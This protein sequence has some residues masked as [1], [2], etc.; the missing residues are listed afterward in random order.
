MSGVAGNANNGGCFMDVTLEIKN[1]QAI[2]RA[3]I[4]IKDFEEFRNIVIAPEYRVVNL[5]LLEEKLKNRIYAILANDELRK[6]YIVSCYVG[7]SYPSLTLEKPSLQMYERII[8]EDFGVEPIGHPFLKPVRK[9]DNYE[10]L[11]SSDNQTH[12]V[13]VGP[14]HAGIIE[15]GHFRFI[16]NGERVNHLEIQLG[17]QHRGVEKLLKNKPSVQLAESICGDSTIAYSLAFCRAMEALAG[18]NIGS[19]ERLIRL[20][21]LEMERMAIHI[22][23]IGAIAGD[24][25]YY[26]A[27]D[28]LA[29]TRTLVINTMLELSGSRFGKGLLKVGGVNYDIDL[30]IQDKIEKML[31]EVKE[32]VDKMVGAMFG[33]ATV[34]SRLENTGIVSKKRAK[35][36]GL[37]GLA[38]R[39][40]GVELDSRVYDDYE[41]FG[42]NI[43]TLASG[44]VY[45]RTSLR[46][47][48][49]KSSAQIITNMMGYLTGEIGNEFKELKL[50]PNCFVLSLV[51]GW[52]GEVAHCVFTEQNSFIDAYKIKDPSI[53]NWFGLALAVRNNQISDFPVC[54][55]SFNLSYCGFDL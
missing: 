15:P 41:Q 53:N 6:L 27:A 47:M 33:H 14:V 40:S 34:L 11:V 55:K 9:L 29:V 19:K 16:C 30:T 28:V 35:E 31:S 2:N 24:I 42:H 48:E 21:A 7:N 43:Q 54:N 5:F 25:G 36:I 4:P 12:E 17:F 18:L 10:F 26:M 50:A 38:G 51:E 23:D 32:R 45:A 1:N 52:R 22:G 39:A 3:E 49:I 46:Y 37:L 13:A 44:D 8:Y 20:I